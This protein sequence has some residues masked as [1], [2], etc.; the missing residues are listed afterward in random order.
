MHATIARGKSFCVNLKL[1]W[2]DN[3]LKL[4]IPIISNK[5]EQKFNKNLMVMM[6]AIRAQH[7]V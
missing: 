3:E 7:L 6:R 1:A 5:N 2:K 4:F